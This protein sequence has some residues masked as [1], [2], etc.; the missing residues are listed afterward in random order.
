[1]K[2]RQKQ[3]MIKIPDKKE[4]IHG[5]LENLQYNRNGADV[6]ISVSFLA[7]KEQ[8]AKAY[9]RTVSTDKRGRLQW[10]KFLQVKKVREKQRE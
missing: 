2:I 7:F 6:G 1:M 10:L 3:K 9:H 4:G 5:L 8:N